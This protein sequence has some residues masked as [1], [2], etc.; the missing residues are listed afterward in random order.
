MFN[1]RLKQ[2]KHLNQTVFI[3][4]EQLSYK[5]YLVFIFGL[6]V[7]GVSVFQ[8]IQTARAISTIHLEIDET[9]NKL[10]SKRKNTQVVI[11]PQQK[12]MLAKIDAQLNYPWDALFSTLESTHTKSISLLTIQP[13][14]EK[15]EVVIS[16]EADSVHEMAELIRALSSKK[17]INH[18][19]LQNHQEI[20]VNQSE[21][22]GFLMLIR[23]KKSVT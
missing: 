5:R 3:K 12:E 22:V 11:D 7:F 8:N 1:L 21:R 9:I 19:E 13:N 6:V 17:I 16:G 20:I 14:M 18:V 2:N 4:N 23:L 15:M 10:N